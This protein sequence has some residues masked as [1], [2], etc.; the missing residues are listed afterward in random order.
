MDET[1]DQIARFID[2]GRV[3]QLEATELLDA[4]AAERRSRA[5]LL[6]ADR[7]LAA[8]AT[9]AMIKARHEIPLFGGATYPDPGQLGQVGVTLDPPTIT[10][11]E[12]NFGSAPAPRVV[13]GRYSYERGTT[14]YLQHLLD[15]DPRFAPALATLI[16]DNGPAAAPLRAAIADGSVAIHYDKVDAQPD[17]K[18]KMSRY[19]LDT[20]PTLPPLPTPG[21]AQEDQS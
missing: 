17:G 1:L 18:I 10:F 13:L 15:R 5:E 6:D 3:S 14:P 9:A 16:D 2:E 20:P 12:S 19:S 21:T 4:L 8:R 11:Y 7:N